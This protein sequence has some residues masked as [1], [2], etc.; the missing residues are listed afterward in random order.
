MQRLEPEAELPL[1]SEGYCNT[2]K[3]FLVFNIAGSFKPLRVLC[4]GL[5]VWVFL[6]EKPF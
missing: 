1:F 3:C 2:R 4:F 5:M 6:E